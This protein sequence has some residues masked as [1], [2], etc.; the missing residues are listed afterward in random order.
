[1]RYF[2]TLFPQDFR[3]FHQ[4]GNG[5]DKVPGHNYLSLCFA[6]AFQYAQIVTSDSQVLPTAFFRQFTHR[7]IQR[8]E[9]AAASAFGIKVF[10]LTWALRVVISWLVHLFKMLEREWTFRLAA[11]NRP[12]PHV[13]VGQCAE[14]VDLT[15]DIVKNVFFGGTGDV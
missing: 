1:M 13:P 12:A 10:Q 7:T 3:P 9:S 4:L 2:Q 5:D 6:I 15:G 11:R 8:F 14:P